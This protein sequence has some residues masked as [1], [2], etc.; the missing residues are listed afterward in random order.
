MISNDSPL[1]VG[2]HVA[3]LYHEDINIV[4]EVG[5]IVSLGDVIGVSLQFLGQQI[6]ISIQEFKKITIGRKKSLFWKTIPCINTGEVPVPR[7]ATFVVNIKD[8]DLGYFGWIPI[9]DIKIE[10]TTGELA[11]TIVDGK[12]TQWISM[13]NVAPG[14]YEEMRDK[15]KLHYAKPQNPQVSA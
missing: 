10:I 4:G 7:W 1:V 6:N 3:I 11:N 5:K 15:L 2:K 12:E 8:E 9:Y 13:D 14:R